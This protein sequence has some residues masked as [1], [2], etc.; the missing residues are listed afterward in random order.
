M[1]EACAPLVFRIGSMR[2][3]LLGELAFVPSP[4]A[5]ADFVEGH[6]R[7]AVGKVNVCKFVASQKEV[8][9]DE[10]RCLAGVGRAQDANQP[11]I[12]SSHQLAHLRRSEREAERNSRILWRFLQWRRLSC[13]IRRQT[14]LSLIAVRTSCRI[15]VKETGACLADSAA[16]LVTGGAHLDCYR[17]ERCHMDRCSFQKSAGSPLRHG[18]L[19]L[20]TGVR[21]RPVRHCAEK[22]KYGWTGGDDRVIG[23]GGG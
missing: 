2:D 21:C 7:A 22:R 5:S 16:F 1:Q 20:G 8:Q 6:K 23:E 9:A 4:G 3:Q 15:K 19:L 11:A 18:A 14:A 13:H 10:H 17:Q 12:S